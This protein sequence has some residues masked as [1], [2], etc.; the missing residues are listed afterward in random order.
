MLLCVGFCSCRHFSS[1]SIHIEPISIF[2]NTEFTSNDDR[3]RKIRWSCNFFHRYPT[4][5]GYESFS[6]CWTK[7]VILSRVTHLFERRMVYNIEIF[8]FLQLILM[9]YTTQS[10]N[11]GCGPHLNI[12][13]WGHKHSYFTCF[14]R[15][16]FEMR[17]KTITIITRYNKYTPRPL[18]ISTMTSQDSSGS[19]RL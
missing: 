6:F 13:S 2:I 4:N 14:F 9:G 10:I 3:S 7:P 8:I 12:C 1:I 15:K 18:W 16:H 5:Y 17:H 11:I 19:L